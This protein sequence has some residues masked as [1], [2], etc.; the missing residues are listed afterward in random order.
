MMREFAAPLPILARSGVM[1]DVGYIYAAAGELLFASSSRRDFRVDA[2]PL[3]PGVTKHADELI[4][5]ELLPGYW[6]D[7]APDRGPTIHPRGI[8]PMPRGHLPRGNLKARG[9]QKGLDAH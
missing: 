6:Y 4:R 5:G 8:A 3:I 2:V 9:Q 1:V 7:A